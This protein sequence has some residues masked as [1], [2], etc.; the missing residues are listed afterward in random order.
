MVAAVGVVGVDVRGL[1][2]ANSAAVVTCGL[3]AIE[4]GVVLGLVLGVEAETGAVVL[5]AG[6]VGVMRAAETPA[7]PTTSTSLALAC[8]ACED[9]EACL[10]LTIRTILAVMTGVSSI[11]PSS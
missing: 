6:T 5:D 7:P 4:L 3:G 10:L 8:E 11:D 1:L 9:C 2:E